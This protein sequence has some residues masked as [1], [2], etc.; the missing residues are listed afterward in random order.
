MPV[1]KTDYDKNYYLNNKDKLLSQAKEK[2]ICQECY[3]VY[4]KSNKT[5]HLASKKHKFIIMENK[6]NELLNS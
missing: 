1:N 5:R 6:I 3:C 4:M 2:V